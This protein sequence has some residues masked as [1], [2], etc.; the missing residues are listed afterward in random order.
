MNTAVMYTRRNVL[1]LGGVGAMAALLRGLPPP[2]STAAPDDSESPLDARYLRHGLNLLCSAH[3]TDAF[4][5]GHAGGAVISAYYLC[6]EEKLEEGSAEIIQ[7][8]LDQHYRL[9][10]DPFPAEKPLENGVATLLRSMED[11]IDQLCRD[12]HNVIFLSLALRA[13]HDLPDSVTPAR[14]DG[15]RKTLQSLEPKKKKKVDVEVPESM[16]GFSEFVLTE[17][18]GSTE[19]GPGQG[20]SGHLLTYGRAILDLRLLGH[21]VF[22]KRCIHAYRLAV[23]TARPR[24]PVGDY[25]ADRPKVKFLRPDQREYWKRRVSAGTLELGHLFKY[26]YGFFGVRKHSKNPELNEVCLNHSHRLFPS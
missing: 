10:P 24:S 15:L 5:G 12:G 3:S 7:S 26:P 17:F 19:G 18:L 21:E 6:R 1:Q 14:I 8:A 9:A 23:Q 16:S 2:I 20:Y 22:A 4:L 13:L 25:K 11:G